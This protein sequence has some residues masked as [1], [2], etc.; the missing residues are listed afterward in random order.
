MMTVAKDPRYARYLKMVQVGV[1]VMAIK[2][3]MILEG[4]DPSLL[5]SPDAPVPDCSK[6]TTTEDHDDASSDS[7]SSFSD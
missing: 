6:K 5:D 2:N 3:K 7:E 1:P 4:L